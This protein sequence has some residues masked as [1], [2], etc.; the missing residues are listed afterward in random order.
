[1]FEV[2]VRLIF[3]GLENFDELDVRARLHAL[4]CAA[5]CLNISKSIVNGAQ[6]VALKR[7]LGEILFK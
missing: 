6:E 1:M 2:N 3:K 4:Q 7:G 5:L